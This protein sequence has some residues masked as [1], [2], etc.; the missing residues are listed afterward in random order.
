MKLRRMFFLLVLLLVP[1]LLYVPAVQDLARRRAVAYASRTLG[2]EVSVERIRLAF[3]LRLTVDNLFD[4][5]YYDAIYDNGGFVYVGKSHIHVQHGSS[6]LLLMNS[7][8]EYVVRVLRS[9]CCLKSFFA[10]RV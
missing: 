4:K 9:Y 1:A 3:P 2:M 10:C 7:F 5:V 8:F 6:L